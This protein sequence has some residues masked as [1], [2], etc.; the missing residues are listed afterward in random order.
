MRRF[1]LVCLAGMA[2]CTFALGVFNVQDGSAFKAVVEFLVTVGL[3]AWIACC[4][5]EEVRHG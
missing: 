2:M 5:D 1:F 3:G 4:L